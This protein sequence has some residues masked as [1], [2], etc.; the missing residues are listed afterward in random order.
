MRFRAL[1]VCFVAAAALTAAEEKLLRLT[2]A[3]GKTCR[4]IIEVEQEVVQS[5][6]PQAMTVNQT[7]RFD[8]SLKSA[9]ADAEG[10]IPLVMTYDRV[11]INQRTPQGEQKYDSA[12]KRTPGVASSSENAFVGGLSGLVGAGFTAV[13]SPR[14]E[15]R[16][17]EGVD[18]LQAKALQG[19]PE[20]PMKPMQTAQMQQMLTEESMIQQMEQILP[21]FPEKAVQVGDR[22][23]QKGAL[24]LGPLVMDVE[25][26]YEV[27]AIR[28]DSVDLKVS[29]TMSSSENAEAASEM[30]ISVKKGT[31]EGT[32][33]VD[34]DGLITEGDAKMDM[35]IEI[36]VQ[37]MVMTQQVSSKAL[38]RRLPTEGPVKDKKK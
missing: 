21:V 26:T 28:S 16:R 23:N 34:S 14:G 1:A 25:T 35:E 19:I 2:L 36:Q 38:A 31:R 29:G 10:N 8:Y 3:A 37:G 5:M 13:V 7:M 32:M 17:V 33:V 18:A 30:S 27:T 12:E 9:A 24:K 4:I 22:W 20:G 15:V 11:A 6:G